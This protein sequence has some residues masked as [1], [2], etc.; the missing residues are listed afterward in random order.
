MRYIDSLIQSRV[1]DNL[2][3]YIKDVRNMAIRRMAYNMG[4]EIQDIVLRDENRDI[5][6][7]LN[8]IQ[9]NAITLSLA[10]KVKVK[11]IGWEKRQK[12]F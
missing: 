2:R 11:Y 10:Q 3:F 1:H 9:A 8:E 5:E 7:I 12:K 6:E 4:K